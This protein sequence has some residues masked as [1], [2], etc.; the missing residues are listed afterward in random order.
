MNP[1]L[2]VELTSSQQEMLLRG[3]RFVRSSV[4]LD[5]RDYSNEVEQERRTKYDEIQE[6]E[7]ILSGASHPGVTA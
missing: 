7:A 2:K 3:L 6:L 5:I 1:E 4:A